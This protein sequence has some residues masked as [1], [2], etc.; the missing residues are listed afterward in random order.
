MGSGLE[1]SAD[2]GWLRFGILI[3]LAVFATAAS[4]G[5]IIRS[6]FL[7]IWRKIVNGY[8]WIRYH[9]QR[10]RC[11]RTVN[12]ANGEFCTQDP[13]GGAFQFDVLVLQY[14][15]RLGQ[16]KA[17]GERI[18]SQLRVTVAGPQ[19]RNFYVALRALFYEHAALALHPAL[20]ND[21]NVNAK[22]LKWLRFDTVV[23]RTDGLRSLNPFL[24][25][26][27]STL[28]QDEA[29]CRSCSRWKKIRSDL[30]TLGRAI[31]DYGYDP[32]IG[33]ILMKHLLGRL[34]GNEA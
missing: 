33:S 17:V 3:A 9:G 8:L 19:L 29:F 6:D 11:C 13:L 24:D 23:R 25:K 21:E 20:I 30:Q 5:I 22:A 10:T 32:R 28:R 14:D 4:T 27:K 16:G 31:G 12:G 26:D 1:F 18:D 34:Y 15:S 2:L 7:G